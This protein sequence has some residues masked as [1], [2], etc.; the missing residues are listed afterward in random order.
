[1]I[2]TFQDDIQ[3]LSQPNNASPDGTGAGRGPAAHAQAWFSRN[4]AIM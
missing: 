3:I 1:M 4:G 2:L